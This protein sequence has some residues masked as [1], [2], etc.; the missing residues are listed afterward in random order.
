M[1]FAF[2]GEDSRTAGGR[3]HGISKVSNSG[4][5]DG[6]KHPGQGT[7]ERREAMVGSTL[8]GFQRWQ[9]EKRTCDVIGLALVGFIQAGQQGRDDGSG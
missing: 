7:W 8:S 5:Q 1:L 9:I 3:L 6:G 4:V 2:Y